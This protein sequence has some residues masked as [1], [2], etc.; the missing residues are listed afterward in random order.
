LTDATQ[1]WFLQQS[2]LVFLLGVFGFVLWRYLL[3]KYEAQQEKYEAALKARIESADQRER[4]R[5]AQFIEAL[6]NLSERHAQSLT[7][8]TTEL[9][10]LHRTVRDKIRRPPAR[11]KPA[12]KAAAV[13]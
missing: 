5:D 1:W 10:E 4:E 3:P 9:A 12:G 7:A 2:G 11:K 8:L 6:K 13:K